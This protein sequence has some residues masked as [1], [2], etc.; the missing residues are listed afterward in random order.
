MIRMFV[1]TE[2]RANFFG[3]ESNKQWIEILKTLLVIL[4]LR[5]ID[6]NNEEDW[7]QIANLMELDLNE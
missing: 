6:L 5:A 1:A 2:K 4:N 3:V 7:F